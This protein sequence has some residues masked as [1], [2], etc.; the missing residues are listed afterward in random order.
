[1]ATTSHTTAPAK[2]VTFR[3]FFAH[4]ERVAPLH[5]SIP[6]VES[7]EIVETRDLPKGCFTTFPKTMTKLDTARLRLSARKF[8][9][10]GTVAEDCIGRVTVIAGGWIAEMSVR[11]WMG[12]PI[13]TLVG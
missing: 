9:S 13:A 5:K 7:T 4:C 3:E 10:H 12:G 8:Q 2:T 11:G 6:F 1:M